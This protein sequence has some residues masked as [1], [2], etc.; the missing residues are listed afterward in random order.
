MTDDVVKLFGNKFKKKQLTGKAQRLRLEKTQYIKEKNIENHR[1]MLIKRN[2]K[3]IGR[4]LSKEFLHKEALK[5]K[6]K[7]EFKK[8]DESAYITARNKGLLNDITSHMIESD[9]NFN[10]PQ[11]FLNLIIKERF[12]KYVIKYNDRKIIY[13]KELDIFIPELNLAIEYNG[14][15][16]HNRKDD[17]LKQILCKDKNI[18]LIKILERNKNSPEY[19]IIDVLKKY[20][21]IDFDIDIIQ[22]QQKALHFQKKYIIEELLKECKTMSEFKSKS[23]ILYNKLMGDGKNSILYK[24]LE[25]D[26]RRTRTKDEI[27]S[28]M[29]KVKTKREFYTKYLKYY[30]SF[31]KYFN[32]DDDLKKIY[33]SLEGRVSPNQ[34]NFEIIT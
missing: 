5:Y 18:I 9:S 32:N 17:K 34:Y 27:K 12:K 8:I 28:H 11:T 3:I 4:D 13:P 20:S 33:F 31:K 30:I 1:L 15:K 25:D 6:T 2:T 21:I 14:R 19:N 22:Y 16:F 7:K 10:Y 24:H 26:M 23:L 29:L